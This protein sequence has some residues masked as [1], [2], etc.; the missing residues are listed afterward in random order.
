[1]KIL[2]AMS[3][4][5]DSSVVAH[6]LKEEGHEVI[7]VRFTLWTDPLAPPLAQ[8]LPSKCCNAQTIARANQVAKD[9]DIELQ[10]LDLEDEFKKDV[11]DP[12]LK[13][14]RE[15]STPNPCIGCNRSVKFGRLLELA[16]SLGCDKLATGH[17]ARVAEEKN[18]NGSVQH[19]LLESI[20]RTKDQS[21]YL[22]GLHQDQLSKVM[23][24]LGG[25]HKSEVF[26]LAVKY[27]IPYDDTSYR[28]SQDLCF[29]PEKEP[30]EFLKRYIT[31]SEPGEIKLEDET[32]VG[33]HKGIP[34]YTI[35]QRKGLGIGGL[36]I[37]LHV[38]RKEPE[39]NTVYVAPNGAD[40]KKELRASDLRWVSWVPPKN[41]KNEFQA[42]IHSLG[43][44]HDGILEHNGDTLDFLFSKGL[45]GIAAGQ[46]I[47]LY[48][49]EEIV[50]GG[51]IIDKVQ[52]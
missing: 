14:Y 33:Q 12:F 20:D 31:D 36:K 45:R 50:G 10:I 2:V 40:L 11:V 43:E 18:T 6:K 46:S 47:V 22:Y 23:F 1:M 16:D 42:R 13:G 35:G 8:I 44:K 51:V 21:Y 34:F 52:K 17:Y 27:G 24:P 4:G 25:L 5:I 28:E 39:T 7:G 9:L 48:R 15:G 19:L 41:Q 32:V 37:P 49:G 26:D 30:E 38:V 29:F 3:G